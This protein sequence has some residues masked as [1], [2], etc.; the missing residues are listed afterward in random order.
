MLRS[1]CCML[2]E[3]DSRQC[4]AWRLNGHKPSCLFSISCVHRNIITVATPLAPMKRRAQLH[5][6][7]DTLCTFIRQRD[8]QNYGPRKWTGLNLSLWHLLSNYAPCLVAC[9]HDQCM[10]T[11]LESLFRQ[12]FQAVVW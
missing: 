11:C 10:V 1:R 7:C 12:V 8:G 4:L 3:T 9:R 2:F 6:T 5:Q